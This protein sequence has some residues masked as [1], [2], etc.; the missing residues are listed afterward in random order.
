MQASMQASNQPTTVLMSSLLATYLW[1]IKIH[2][3]KLK[4][5]RQGPV[6]MGK[7]LEV[8]SCIRIR[9]TQTSEATQVNTWCVDSNKLSQKSDVANEWASLLA[10]LLPHNSLHMDQI[11]VPR[12]FVAD[13][14]FGVLGHHIF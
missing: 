13:T 10:H 7:M 6:A 12:P 2:I 1:V 14:A 9:L 8:L 11:K 3:H 4:W 5:L